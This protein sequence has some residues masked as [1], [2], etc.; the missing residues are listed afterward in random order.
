MN[1]HETLRLESALEEMAIAFKEDFPPERKK[2]YLRVF[3]GL[4]LDHVL[5]ACSAWLCSES[6]FFP[7]PGQLRVLAENL[8]SNPH[9]TATMAAR[10]EQA[11][12]NLRGSVTTAPYNRWALA[13]PLTAQVFQVLGGGFMTPAGFG[14]WD[15]KY[16]EV[17]HREFVGTYIDLA[18]QYIDLAPLPT[19]AD[20]R[21]IMTRD[22]RRALTDEEIPSSDEVHTF[23]A[24][25]LN[26]L[27]KTL[28]FPPPHP[29]KH[30]LREERRGGS[31]EYMPSL[32]P[33]ELEARKALLLRQGHMIMAQELAKKTEETTHVTS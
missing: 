17:K 30:D 18:P 3:A 2:I 10:A 7:K 25:L 19:E 4:S 21:A 16:E 8:P 29:Y 11:W 31:L 27:E 24:A 15:V 20:A 5:A 22:P 33:I 12:H 14:Q 23:V 1:K 6:A 9:G 26:D 13:D 28:R 32:S